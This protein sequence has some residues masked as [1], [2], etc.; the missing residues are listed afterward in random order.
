MNEILKKIDAE[1]KESQQYCEGE[2]TAGLYKAK[3]IIK[4][5]EEEESCAGC[6]YESLDGE[7]MPCLHCRQAYTDEYEPVESEDIHE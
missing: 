6:K 2:Y 4:T 1:I 7:E 5:T 3:E